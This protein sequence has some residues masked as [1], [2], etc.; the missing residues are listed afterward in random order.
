MDEISVGY[1]AS[2][3]QKAELENEGWRVA[4]R[5]VTRAED[6]DENLARFCYVSGIL[7]TN[8]IGE[9]TLRC[10][11]HGNVIVETTVLLT[12]AQP[13]KWEIRGENL[14]IDG[15][16]EI[17]Q[18]GQVVYHKDATKPKHVHARTNPAYVQ[19]EKVTLHGTFT[20]L[21]YGV[22]DDALATGWAP[23][24]LF[25][26]PRYCALFD[27]TPLDRGMLDCKLEERAR[28]PAV[29]AESSNAASDADSAAA[30]HADDDALSD[31]NK[32]DENGN[33]KDPSADGL[34]MNLHVG[35]NYGEDL[36]L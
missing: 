31:P 32:V 33:L 13:A 12:T 8:D 4:F 1:G 30:A 35:A 34:F 9:S 25:K 22:Y 24:L 15:R 23:K 11:S 10:T 28:A 19:S 20:I 17:V 16:L 29:D 5:H 18:N 3:L 6:G 27:F 36:E 26:E 14:G 21:L 2:Y 7:S